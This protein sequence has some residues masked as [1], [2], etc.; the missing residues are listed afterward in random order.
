MINITL[1]TDRSGKHIGMEASGHA[2][3]AR[4]GS[5]IIC[6]AVSALT[7]NFVNS[8]EKLTGQSFESEADEEGRIRVIFKEETEPEA[9]LLLDSYMLGVRSVLE[10][11]GKQ[12]IRIK[13]REVK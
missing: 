3:Y 8:L 7:I 5:D 2:G 4:K 12:Y 13:T 6:A 1:F 10:D 9:A 11:Y